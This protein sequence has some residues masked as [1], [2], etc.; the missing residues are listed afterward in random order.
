ME[1]EDKKFYELTEDERK[2]KMQKFWRKAKPILKKI[3][4]ALF[5]IAI[6]LLMIF[7]LLQGAFSGDVD[8]SVSGA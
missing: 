7:A 5:C 8:T 2:E 3:L 6:C 4:F 1:N